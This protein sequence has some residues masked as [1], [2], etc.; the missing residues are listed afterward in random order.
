[1][2]DEKKFNV[3]LAKHTGSYF[4]IVL[5]FVIFKVYD[6]VQTPK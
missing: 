2:E 4:G 6:F 1:M 3:Q 5:V